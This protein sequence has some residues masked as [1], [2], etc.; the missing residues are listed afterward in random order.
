M[1]WS[2]EMYREMIVSISS[3]PPSD[4]KTLEIDGTYLRKALA[5]ACH[6]KE[7]TFPLEWKRNLMNRLG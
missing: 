2:A 5:F 7:Y 4:A 1:A 6:Q 3:T